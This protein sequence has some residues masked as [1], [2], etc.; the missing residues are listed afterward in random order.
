M[1]HRSATLA[2][3]FMLLP[4]MCTPLASAE[5]LADPPPP[6]P[7]D[8]LPISEP[9][10]GPIASAPP[11]VLKTPDG[12]V[13]TVAGSKESMEAVAPLTTALS[14]REY[15]VDGTFTGTITGG[16][17][18][19]LAGGS[20]EAGYRIGC[21]IIGGPDEL[22]GGLGLTP[23][24]TG[25][26]AGLTPGANFGG[27]LLQG[28]IKVNLKPGTVNIVP[29][30]KKSYKGASTRVTITGFRVKVDGCVGQSF[31]QSY[32]TMTSSTDNTDDVITYLGVTR[33]V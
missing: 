1:L 24:L 12:W 28:Q 20:M 2:A 23:G 33:A 16:G 22:L 21:G 26:G 32:A 17:K 13:V 30:D 14:S 19:K 3:I 10:S 6:P 15:L 4:I 9:A 5:P 27:T 25:L 29:V 8:G 11:G 31:I 7:P 18:T